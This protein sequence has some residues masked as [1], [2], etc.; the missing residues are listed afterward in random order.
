MLL[1]LLLHV[2]LVR[3]DGCDLFLSFES[4]FILRVSLVV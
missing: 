1:L 4:G 3:D 2:F